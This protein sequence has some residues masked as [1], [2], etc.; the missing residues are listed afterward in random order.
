MT[1]IRCEMLQKISAS[2]VCAFVA[3]LCSSYWMHYVKRLSFYIYSSMS[4]RR[5][6]HVHVNN[7][8]RNRGMKKEKNV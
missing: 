2:C 6:M 4:R 8:N 5:L 7:N 1:L 3:S